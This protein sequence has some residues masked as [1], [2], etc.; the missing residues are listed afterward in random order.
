M[1]RLGYSNHHSTFAS[2]AIQVKSSEDNTNPIPPHKH[3]STLHSTLKV[4]IQILYNTTKLMLYINY[5]D[6]FIINNNTL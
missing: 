3:P 2:L 4:R 1:G 6:I 5:K